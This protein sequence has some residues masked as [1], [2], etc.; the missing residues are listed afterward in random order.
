M[1]NPTAVARTPTPL[2]RRRNQ[3]DDSLKE[4]RD[5]ASD[6]FSMIDKFFGMLSIATILRL[7]PTGESDARH[8]EPELQPNSYHHE[9]IEKREHVQAGRASSWQ[10]LDE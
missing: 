6:Q 4:S 9:H 3:V 1:M 7:L 2:D 5:A 10:W 8:I